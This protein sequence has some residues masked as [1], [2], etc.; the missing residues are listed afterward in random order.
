MSN[1]KTDIDNQTKDNSLDTQNKIN[2]QINNQMN[3]R[4]TKNGFVQ[5]REEGED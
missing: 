2:N 3:Q 1:N 5:F 4:I